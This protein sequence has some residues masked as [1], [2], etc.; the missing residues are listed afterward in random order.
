MD[1]DCKGYSSI[2]D[3]DRVEVT[4]RVNSRVERQQSNCNGLHWGL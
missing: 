4:Q 2:P 3:A 1:R